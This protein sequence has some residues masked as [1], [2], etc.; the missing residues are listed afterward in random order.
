MH[1]IYTADEAGAM[2][3]HT[4]EEI[5][6]QSLVLM[7][8][9]GMAI[10]DEIE[11][12]IYDI[13]GSNETLK[14]EKILCIAGC[15]NNGGDVL[16]AARQLQERGYSPD[17][18]LI[19]ENTDK[20]SE[21]LRKQISFA[22]KIGINFIRETDMTSYE[23][24]VDGIF[25]NG[26]SRNVEGK[27]KEIIEAVNGSHAFVISADVPSGL[28]ASNGKICGAC[29]QADV[30]VTFGRERLGSCL[31]PGTIYSGRAVVSNI[32]FD[33]SFEKHMDI[34]NFLLDDEDLKRI[35]RRVSNSNKGTFGRV[36][37]IAGSEDMGGA[38][39]LS[40]Q[41]AL[42]SGAGLVKVYTHVSNR[43][44]LISSVPE[45]IVLTYNELDKNSISADLEREMRMVDSIVIG[46]GLSTNETA[47]FITEYVITHASGKLIVDADAINILSKRKDLSEFL[48][49]AK[50]ERLIMTPHIKEMSRLSKESVEN[51]LEDRISIAVRIANSLGADIILKDSTTLVT[52]GN[53]A[54]INNRPNSGMSTP[55]S[56]DVLAGML[57]GIAAQGCS[58][59]DIALAGVYL[60]SSCG[61]AAKNRL[62]EYSMLAGDIVN[63]LADV[64]K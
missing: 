59:I 10:T 44:P 14:K 30:T 17:V 53:I 24:I 47:E 49:K 4:I 41:A 34:K 26:L 62:G 48:S 32:G 42:R 23:I 45:A 7:E 39:V 20:L 38:A 46:P 27:Y 61:N 55:G 1:S 16:T 3:K 54:A 22:E 58:G 11:K 6:I 9:A 63:G 15:G 43:V 2:D 33:M 5:G 40:V 37:I 51:I 36:L 25:G 29:V 18:L 52:D 8:R 50:Y 64:I 57:A 31:A 35:P 28:N 56:G 21:D 19:E 13:H 12:H 60:H